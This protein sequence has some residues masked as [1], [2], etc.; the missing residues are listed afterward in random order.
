[1]SYKDRQ[2]MITVYKV[3]DGMGWVSFVMLA[4]LMVWVASLV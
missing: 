4:A 2:R 3:R 1:M